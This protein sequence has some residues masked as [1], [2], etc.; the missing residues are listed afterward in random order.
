MVIH[1]FPTKYSYC[2]ESHDWCL[3]QCLT[4]LSQKHTLTTSPT[5]HSHSNTTHLHRR[6]C[7]QNQ[8]YLVPRD[9]HHLT[10]AQSR[11]HYHSLVPI[12]WVCLALVLVEQGVGEIV[13]DTFECVSVRNKCSYFTL[14]INIFQDLTVCRQ[15][16]T[17]AMDSGTTKQQIVGGL[18]IDDIASYL[19][20]KSPIWHLS[21]IFFNKCVL[22]ELKSKRVV[23]MA[24]SW[25]DGIPGLCINCRGMMLKA[26]PGFTW[27]RL[28]TV[29]PI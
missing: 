6:Q 1:L 2:F 28:T 5:L 19:R 17:I 12:V 11:L 8:D 22:L 25:Y 26:N 9:I 3:E 16:G 29:D 24:L 4:G 14:V 20:H 7:Y 13:L 15:N 10:P 21:F 18:S 23:W 27:M